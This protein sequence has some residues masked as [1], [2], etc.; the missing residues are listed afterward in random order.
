MENV[1]HARLDAHHAQQSIC[2]YNAHVINRKLFLFLAFFL[3]IQNGILLAE[4]AR[5]NDE[6]ITLFISN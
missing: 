2:A 5:K 4:K 3:D 6:L 1:K